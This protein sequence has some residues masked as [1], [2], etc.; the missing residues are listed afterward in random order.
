MHRRDFLILGGLGLG[1]LA[2]PPFGRV[3]AAEQLQSTLDVAFK[4]RL[5][6]TALEAATGAGADYCDVRIGR[7]LQ[8]SLMTREDKVENVINTESTGVGIRV[9]AN[10]AWGFAATSTLTE[11]GVAQAARQA[12]AIAKANAKIQTEPVQ[13][14]PVTGVG[15]VSW[16]TPIRKNA[17]KVPVKEKVDLLLGVNAAAMNAGADFI[18][19]RMFLVN[20]Q[21]YFASTDGSYI[22]QD[23]HRIWAPFTVTAIGKDSGKFR[24]RDGLA[25]PM[26]LGFEYLD[27]DPTG[28]IELPGGVV[29]YT[30][31]YD[32]REDAIAAAKQAREKLKAPSVKPGKYD[33]VLDPSNL[34]LTIHE[35]VGHPLELDRVLGY[36]ANYAGTSFATLDKREDGFRWGSDIVN[37][38]ADKV[39]PGSLGAVG[40]DDEGVKT[41]RWDLVREGVLVD[42]QATRDQAHIL[43]KD[44]SD[45]CSYADSWSS[46]QFQRMPNVSLAPGREALSVADMIKG[47]ERGIYIHGR[48]SY[49]IDQQRYNAQF[50]GQLYYEIKDGEIAGMLEDVAYQIRT[51]EFWGACSAICDA[52]DFRLG[53]SFFD[54]KGQPGQVSAV[55]HGSATTRFDGI[56]VINTARSL[57]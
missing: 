23:V 20:E 47:V 29:A 15:E 7:Y 33:L 50:G 52:R 37:F 48:G 21:K 44:A 1:G 34:F 26:G 3:I 46:V 45:G 55:S 4:K 24:T 49:S 40:F 27:A 25:P 8:Q 53:G 9:I 57:G 6:D 12:T 16:R 41:K 28:R 14:A 56:N 39:Q 10:G 13:L 17:M 22:D 5:A 38:F 42:Y 19:S 2:L 54:G 35:N 11:A 30:T 31:A 43:G 51:P 18:A 36:E 32:M